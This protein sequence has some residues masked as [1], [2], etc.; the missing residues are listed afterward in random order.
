MT[1]TRPVT[2]QEYTVFADFCLERGIALDGQDGQNN[3]VKF[4]NVLANQNQRITREN[5]EAVYQPIKNQLVHLDPVT[6]EYNRLATYFP[7]PSERDAIASFMNQQGLDVQDY[8]LSNWNVFAKFLIEWSSR[9]EFAGKP[10]SGKALAATPENL[11]FALAHIPSSHFQWKQQRSGK[12]FDSAAAVKEYEAKK[13]T[14]QRDEGPYFDRVSGTV[15]RPL[16]GELKAHAETLHGKSEQ[17]KPE[18]ENLDKLYERKL[19]DLVNAV[20]SNVIREECRQYAQ[21]VRFA[22]SSARE[23]FEE[24]SSWLERRLHNFRTSGWMS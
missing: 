14:V 9:P 2:D 8:L 10:Y 17:I 22:S 20:E 18:P 11:R 6:A 4:G 5:L 19:A 12:R 21:K 23:A 24:V 13:N 7:E 1:N 15:I 3:G 16:R